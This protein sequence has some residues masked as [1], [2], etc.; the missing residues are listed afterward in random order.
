MDNK[1]LEIER[2]TE[3]NDL[4]RAQ[5]G[6]LTEQVEYCKM[7]ADNFL[8]DY[9]KAQKQVDELKAENARLNNCVMS[10]EQVRKCCSDII[11]ET[12]Q[13]AVKDT[14]KEILQGLVEKAYSNECIDLTVNEVKALFREDY[15]V[16]V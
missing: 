6:L 1:K 16:E 9:Q 4:Q 10:E 8:A 14:A 2:L 5:V 15:G 3:E 7:C 12:R 13:Q 11:Q